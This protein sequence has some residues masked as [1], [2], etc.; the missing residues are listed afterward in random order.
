MSK[1]FKVLSLILI[2]FSTACSWQKAEDMV[3][4]RPKRT[5]YGNDQQHIIL[6]QPTNR[7][8]VTCYRS[9]DVSAETCAKIFESK[10]YVRLR[11][12]PYN[13]ADYDFL[14]TDT[15]PSRRWRSNENSP[16]W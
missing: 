15:Y 11:N 14:K 10:G 9:E 5:V 16:R 4:L 1:I 13:T 2:V 7:S 8:I 3:N 6:Q 12:I